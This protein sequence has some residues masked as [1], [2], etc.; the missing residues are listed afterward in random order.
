MAATSIEWTDASWNPLRARDPLTGKTGWHCVHASDGC[1]HCYAEPINRRFGTT[2]PYAAPST[3]RVETYLDEA[4]LA[5]PL[6]WRKPRRAFPCSM[7]DLFGDWVADAQRDRMFA[8]MALTPHV[9]WQIATKRPDRARAYLTDP[10]LGLRL[11]ARLMEGARGNVG[12]ESWVLELAWNLSLGD[13]HLPNVWIGCS[14][15]DQKNADARRPAMAQIAEAGWL[16]WVSYEPALGPVDWT[17]WE[18]LRWLVAGGESGPKA[19]IPHPDWIRDTRDWCAAAAV[20]FFFKQWGRWAP[21]RGEDASFLDHARAGAVYVRRDGST[22]RPIDIAT[23]DLLT[24]DARLM[25]PFGKKAAGRLLDGVE[26]SAFPT[27][28][29]RAA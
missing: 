24:H 2:L 8:V 13:H 18:H 4:V 25:R 10:D 9:T 7:T 3:A 26:H 5:Q 15:E 19:R 20:A 23:M 28:L 22:L 12:A 14:V 16:T 27:P 21:A 11:G 17:G 1:R 6:R 29:A